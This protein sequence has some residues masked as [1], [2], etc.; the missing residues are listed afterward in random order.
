MSSMV[1]EGK[2]PS[3]LMPS[4]EQFARQAIRTIG[5][6]KETCGCLSHQFLVN[7]YLKIKLWHSSFL[8]NIAEGNDQPDAPVCGGHFYQKD[9]VAN[10]CQLAQEPS[11]LLMLVAFT[12][13]Q[14]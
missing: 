2:K 3:F 12:I 14:L 7:N 10:S 5:H 6:A 1:S 11:A 4:A 9:D 13:T 8:N